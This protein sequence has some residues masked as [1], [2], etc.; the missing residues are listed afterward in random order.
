MTPTSRRKIVLL[1]G[2]GLLLN[3][4]GCA[5]QAFDAQGGATRDL[6]GFFFVVAT[7]VF[8]IVV[9]LISWSIIRYRERPGDAM[10]EQ[11]HSNIRLELL[12][13]AIPQA[14][15]IA[16]FVFSLTTL[17]EIEDAPPDPE[18]TVRV[19]G[20]QWGWRFEYEDEGVA[21]TSEA[22]APAQ[23]VLPVGQEI[24]FELVSRDVIHSFYIPRLWVKRDTI[25]GKVNNLYVTLTEE[26]TFRGA[27]AEFC[28]L[29]HARM[30]F[31]VRAV[32]GD[33]FETWLS[34]QTRSS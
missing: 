24:V 28:G 3:M 18:V 29:L 33:E 9:G 20:F 7:G 10:P 21:I 1:A 25:P 30:D 31:T 26:G 19:Q 23:L 17:N 14:L 13:F 27:C 4:S 2:T 8:V 22:Q 6:Y 12:W 16:L 32:P 11:F 5:P 34:E 15:V